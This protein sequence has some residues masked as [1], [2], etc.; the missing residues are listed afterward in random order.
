[1]QLLPSL[2]RLMTAFTSIKYSLPALNVIAQELTDTTFPSSTL[3]VNLKVRKSPLFQNELLLENICFTYPVGTIALQDISLSIKKGQSIAFVGPS[4]SGK[5][6]LADIIL[7]L[8]KP[9]SGKILIDGLGL[10]DENLNAWHQHLGYIPQSIYL[11]DCTIKENI[12]FGV[13]YEEVPEEKVWKAL[14][15]ASLKTFVEGLTEKLETQVGENGV[16]LSGGQRQRIGIARALYRDPDVLVMDEATAALDNQTEK[17]VTQ[18]IGAAVENR[19]V[20]TIAHR[21]STIKNCTVIY[22]L[23]QGKV[24]AKGSYNMLI[25]QCDLFQH[26]VQIETKQYI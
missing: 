26:L 14:N 5:T 8:L 20:I 21:L 23:D 7:G 4:G 15:M 1:M 13:P 12:A 3:S 2:N 25:E 17:E 18:A 6:T 24:V 10:T 16:R 9:Q 22:V 11:Y 19:T